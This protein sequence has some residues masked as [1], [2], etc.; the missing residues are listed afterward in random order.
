M[1]KNYFAPYE[2]VAKIFRAPSKFV[3]YFSYPNHI[4]SARVRGIKNGRS[5][6]PDRHFEKKQKLSVL[7][8]RPFFIPGTRAERIWLG[9]EKYLTI[10]DGARKIFA[11]ILWGAK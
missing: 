5:L 8:D 7:R 6:R 2:I 3:K 4:R 11:T 10:F 1:S 9:Y